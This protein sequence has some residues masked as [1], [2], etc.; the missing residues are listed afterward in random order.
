MGAGSG[1]R[2]ETPWPTYDG[3]QLPDPPSK[4]WVGLLWEALLAEYHRKLSRGICGVFGV[5]FKGA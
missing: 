4:M 1:K 5:R 3:P 2:D